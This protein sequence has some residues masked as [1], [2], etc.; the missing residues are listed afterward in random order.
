MKMP[1][2]EQVK[3]WP[4]VAYKWV[5]VMK[6]RYTIPGHA[7][8]FFPIG[9]IGAAYEKMTTSFL[10][11]GYGEVWLWGV[12]TGTLFGVALVFI[13][14]WADQRAHDRIKEHDLKHVALHRKTDMGNPNYTRERHK[15]VWHGW[16]WKD[17]IGCTIGSMVGAVT[18]TVLYW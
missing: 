12:L 1:T 10:S 15:P 4:K 7:V 17:V 6:D 13:Q 16:D 8:L 2:V 11:Y 18:F 3:G 5:I 14:E 9:F